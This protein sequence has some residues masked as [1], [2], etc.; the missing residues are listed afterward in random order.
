M[1]NLYIH[2]AEIKPEF[3][4]KIY[5]VNL[6]KIGYHFMDTHNYPIIDVIPIDDCSTKIIDR[7]FNGFNGDVAITVQRQYLFCYEQI[8]YNYYWFIQ[9]L[10]KFEEPF[11][12]IITFSYDKGLVRLDSYMDTHDEFI[13]GAIH[14]FA[15]MVGEKRRAKKPFNLEAIYFVQVCNILE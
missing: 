6:S 5:S 8:D 9:L 3:F 11:R 4:N 1:N 12:E 2:F 15:H 13:M 7:T 10:K 14:S